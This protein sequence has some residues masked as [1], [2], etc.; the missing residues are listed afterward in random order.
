MKQQDHTNVSILKIYQKE[1]KSLIR[2]FGTITRNFGVRPMESLLIGMFRASQIQ[3]IVANP[4]VV[5][6]SMKMEI[7]VAINLIKVSDLC[8]RSESCQRSHL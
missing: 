5:F 7:V 4:C 2:V 3:E 6:V 1:P 8:W